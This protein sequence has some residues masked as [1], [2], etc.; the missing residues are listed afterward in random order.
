MVNSFTRLSL[1]SRVGWRGLYG[2]REISGIL[3]QFLGQRHAA[4][5]RPCCRTATCSMPTPTLL[6]ARLRSSI[7]RSHS[8]KPPPPK[9]NLFS[10]SRPALLP[11]DN[12]FADIVAPH[13]RDAR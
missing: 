8:R 4:K 10:T 6:S 2:P 3:R 13:R 12:L 11:K 9:H 1:E 7:P 5:T